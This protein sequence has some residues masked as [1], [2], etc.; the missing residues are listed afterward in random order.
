MTERKEWVKEYH[1]PTV[2]TTYHITVDK[3]IITLRALD[4]P[5]KITASIKD[6]LSLTNER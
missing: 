1:T 6:L 3:D 2:G 5:Y 4:K